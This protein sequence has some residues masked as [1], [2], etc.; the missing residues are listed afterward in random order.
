M[1]LFSQRAGIRS[2][3]KVIQRES[4]DDELRNALWTAFH[5]IFVN[6]YYHDEGRSIPYYPH[7]EELELWLYSL[8]TGFYKAPSDTQPKFREAIGQIRADFFRLEW[9]W[10]FDFLEFSAKRAKE[11]GPLLI[12]FVNVQLQRENSAYRFVGTEIVEITDRQELA[13]IE[14]ALSGPKAAR[15]HFERALDLLSDRRAPDFRNSIKESISA[16][17]AVCRLIANSQSDTLGA[18]LKKISVKAP[19]HPAFEQALLKLYGFTSDEGGIRHA[20]ME[21]TSLGYAD[22]K[23]MLVLCSAFANFLLARCAEAGVKLK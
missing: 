20:L 13:S 21:E 4:I 1:A 17:E 12:K 3:N 22:A 15:I 9:H 10:V 23:F 16:V 14:E 2:L 7:R 11:C 18:A 19:I 5:D 8:W 6:A